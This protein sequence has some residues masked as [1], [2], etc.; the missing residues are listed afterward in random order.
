VSRAC[1]RTRTRAHTH[2]HTQSVCLSVSIL[3]AFLITLQA[4]EHGLAEEAFEIYKKFDKKVEAICVLLEHVPE[5]GLKRAFDYATKVSLVQSLPVT[6]LLT[7]VCVCVCVRVLLEHVP[8][9][10]L[11]RAFDYA[12][13]VSSVCRA[14]L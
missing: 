1:K 8:E 13:K 7:C 2:T 10:S 6:P 9:D 14:Y 11:K 5:D 12:T 4:I 3:Y